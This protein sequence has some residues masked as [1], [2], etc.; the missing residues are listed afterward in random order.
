MTTPLLQ[1][2]E[3][4]VEICT[5][6]NF[7]SPL[8][9][10]GIWTNISQY[11]SAMSLGPTGREHLLDRV[12]AAPAQITV[13]NR[14]GTFNPWNTNSILYSNGYGMKPMNHVRVIASWAGY[15]HPI[16]YGYL[17]SITPVIHDVLNVEATLTC[18]DIFQLFSLKYLSNN[19]YAQLVESDGGSNLMAYYRCGDGAG[20]YFVSDSSGNGNTGTLQGGAVMG[21]TGGFLYDANTAMDCTAGTGAGQGGFCTIDYTTEPPSPHNPLNSA[22]QSTIEMWMQWTS[23]TVPTNFNGTNNGTLCQGTYGSNIFTMSVGGASVAAAL[24]TYV[25]DRVVVQWSTPGISLTTIASNAADVMDGHWH[26]VAVVSN[27]GL[28]SLYVDGY[29]T[30]TTTQTTANLRNLTVGY[31]NLAAEGGVI[32]PPFNGYIQDVAFYNTALTSTQIL[33][34]YQT[35]IWFQTAEYGAEFGTTAA[36]RLNKLLAVVGLPVSMLTPVVGFRTEMYAETNPITTT[37]ALN[38]IQTMSETEPGLIFQGPDGVLYAYDR[39]Y[40]YHNPKSTTSL[41]IFSDDPTSTYYYDGTQLQ[42]VQDDLDVFNDVQVQS[43]RTT[44]PGLLQEWGPTQSAAAAT[45]ASVYGT[46]TLQGLTSLQFQYDADALAVAQNYSKW[47]NFPLVRVS[48]IALSSTASGGNNLPQMLGRGLYD[49]VTIKYQGQT[50]STQFVQ[51]AL[52]ES[53]THNIDI[54]NGPTWTTVWALSPYEIIMTPIIFDTWRFG[55]PASSGV[56]TL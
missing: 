7:Q 16:Y 21:A 44:P 25:Y 9:G 30:A 12:Q 56:L 24:G 48:Q 46:R 39:Q 38:Y 15:T 34:H 4:T 20:S 55:S 8:N 35:G 1:F 19:N 6:S 23:S 47:Y 14:D 28:S 51:D 43:G 33:N 29:V 49:R 2:P 54:T 41:G 17:Q 52:I 5:T 45:S 36:G 13:S 3:V 27:A 22:T 26:H 10:N 50:G 11:V 32:L 31:S 42:I 53:I 37:S 40:Q 18:V